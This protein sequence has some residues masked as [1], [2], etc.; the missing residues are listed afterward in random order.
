MI[1]K[2]KIWALGLTALMVLVMAGCGAAS[3]AKTTASKK[4]ASGSHHYETTVLFQDVFMKYQGAAAENQSYD[5]VLQTLNALDQS[6]YTVSEDSA[7]NQITVVQKDKTSPSVVFGFD[8]DRYCTSIAFNIRGKGVLSKNT[9]GTP[10]Y[11]QVTG[12]SK[13]AVSSIDKLKAFVKTW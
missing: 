2:N 7:N 12:S 9:N 1:K 8:K 4:T 10:K 6:A 5:E 3:S 13:K 11:Y